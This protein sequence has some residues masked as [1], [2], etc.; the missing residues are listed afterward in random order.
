MM[1]NP[2]IFPIPEAVATFERDREAVGLIGDEHGW[3]ISPQTASR[4]QAHLR[5]LLP[6]ASSGVVTAQYAVA[7]MYLFG[8]LYASETE[9]IAR[10]GADSANAMHWL[11]KA[12]CAGHPGAIDNLLTI[13]NGKEAARLLGIYRQNASLFEKA[14]APSKGWQ[15][16]MRTLHQLAY[17]AN[18][19][20]LP[21]FQAFRRW[22]IA[23]PTAKDRW[24]AAVLG[25]F[26]FF[27]LGLFARLMMEAQVQLDEWLLAP[28]SVRM[29]VGILLPKYTLTV[30]FPFAIFG[31]GPSS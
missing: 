13:G 24:L 11:E 17:G 29:L 23:P 28:A 4:F 22:W 21:G 6:L 20:E 19:E 9:A 27:W 8:Y 18:G 16:N 25:G 10:H 2:F 15:R 12:A 31:G 7:V 1:E 26:A 5:E 14:L 30:C 3:Y